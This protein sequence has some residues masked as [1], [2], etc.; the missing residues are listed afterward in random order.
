MTDDSTHSEELKVFDKI[1]RKISAECDRMG[2]CIPYIPEH[3]RYA[4]MGRK[5]I[6][7]WTNGFWAG[8][9]WQ[10]FH[11]TGDTKYRDTAKKTEQRLDTALDGFT[12]LDHDVGFMWLLSSVAGFRLT[13]NEKSKTRGLHAATI[14]AGRYNPRGKFIRAWNKNLTGWIIVDSLMNLPLLYWASETENDPRFRFIAENHADTVLEKIARPD[15]SCNH[16]AVLDPETGALLET[17]AGQGYA[18]GSSWSRGQAWALYGFALSYRHTG[19][20]EYLDAARRTAHYFI[21][22]V[23]ETGYIPASDF[24]APAEP[25][26][27][28]T[29]A[30]TCA[31]CGLLELAENVPEA[32]KDLYRKPAEHILC[33]IE[34]TYGD[35][36]PDSDSIVAGGSVSYK[37]GNEVPLIY[38]DYFFIEGI[39]RLLKKAALLW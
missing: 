11:V 13:G 24:R 28:D 2:D 19:K 6:Y 33:A 32:E 29:S 17:P 5:N 36:N 21:S 1:I 14:L 4:D 39:L 34:K 3:G 7:W 10:M 12:G 37:D 18:P 27:S 8:I 23:S 15:G 26:I 38:G 22:C 9:L 35:W 20:K 25:S 16:I 31:A 30:G